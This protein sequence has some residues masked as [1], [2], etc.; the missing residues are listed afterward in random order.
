VAAYAVDTATVALSTTY[1]K[2]TL[3]GADEDDA[4]NF[5]E[6]VV[7]GAAVLRL[8]TIAGGAASVTW[9]VSEDSAGDAPIAGPV[10]STIVGQ[11]AAT[12][13]VA[14]SIT[15]PWVVNAVDGNLYV[16]AKLDAGTANCTKAKI[17]FQTPG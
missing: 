12:G 1:A 17:S 5:P 4:A 6:R 8:D 11:T 9:Y 13:G 2:M 3:N 7:L 10:T 16:W 14:E 15:V